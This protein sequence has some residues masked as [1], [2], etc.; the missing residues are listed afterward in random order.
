MPNEAA[1][2]KAIKVG[3]FVCGVLAV[4]DFTVAVFLERGSFRDLDMSLHGVVLEIA[5]L[6]V[7]VGWRLQKNS[8]VFAIL[9]LLMTA[10][11]YH[12]KFSSLPGAILPTLVV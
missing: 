3:V 1:A 6:Y 5:I 7:I 12:D 11:F 9:G 4:V 8:K 10:Y 2:K